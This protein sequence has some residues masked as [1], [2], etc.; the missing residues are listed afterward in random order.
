MSI[1]IINKSDTP[2]AF[3]TELQRDRWHIKYSDLTEICQDDSGNDNRLGWM[4][5]F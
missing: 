5:V 2:L 3:A 1:G 4:A